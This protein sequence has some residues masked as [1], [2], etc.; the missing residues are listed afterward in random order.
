MLLPEKHIKLSESLFAL[1]AF[2][3]SC[4]N[5]PKNVDKIWQEMKQ[6]NYTSLLP[7][8]H[9]YDNFLLSI[10]YLFTIGAVD[11]DTEGNIYLCD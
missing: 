4:L 11:M 5:K 1:G 6:K 10:D 8:N 9:S 3:L 7:A 2:V